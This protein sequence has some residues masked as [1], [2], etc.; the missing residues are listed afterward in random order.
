MISIIKDEILITKYQKLFVKQLKTVYDKKV[1]CNLGFQGDSF[2]TSVFYSTHHNF[3]FSPEETKNRYWNAFGI[4]EPQSGKGVSINVEINFPYDG[5]NRNIGGAFGL[6]RNGEVLVL[7]RG[8]IGGGRVGIGKNLFFNNFRGEFIE[9]DDDGVVN[10]FAVIGSLN[11]KLFPKQISSFI[12]EVD[13]IKNFP[14]DEAPDFSEIQNFCYTAEH[15]GTSKTKNK[16]DRT[17]ERVHG[18]VVNELAKLLEAQ[19]QEVANDC[20]RDKFIHKRGKI[21]ALFEIKTS[22][23]TQSLYSAVG[24]LLIY[25]IPI[26]GPVNLFLVLPE[27]LNK[28][29]EKRLHELGLQIIYYCW[30]EDIPEFEDLEQAL[31]DI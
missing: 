13:R 26:K 22:S 2:E 20:N 11:S 17:I 30:A 18:I 8:K 6:N 27:K 9:A 25:S 15:L 21:K 19:G 14:I 1:P 3:W 29:V 7:H 24:Q 5:I 12:K 16:G 28:K 4:G 23:S 10:E 31:N